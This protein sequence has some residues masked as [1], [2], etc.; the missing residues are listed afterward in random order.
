MALTK[1]I[2]KA[3]VPLIIFSIIAVFLMKGLNRNPHKV[4]SPLIGKSVP[5]FSANALE[6][7]EN[8]LTNKMFQGHVSLLNV[9]SSWCMYCRIE[10]PILI[11]I[12]NE[13]KLA[14][15]GLDYK[16]KRASAISWLKQLGNPYSKIIFDPRG[17]F[18]LNLGVY[19]TPETFIIDKKGVIRYKH[20]GPISLIEWKE[21]LLPVV[22]R[23][24]RENV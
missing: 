9:F 16:D 23:L 15:Y 4:P 6:M 20:V 11:D 19:G 18:A 2:L 24:Q 3:L 22:N 10:N 7:P 14:I 21:E 8:I 12:K 17:K 13:H 5:S 1:L